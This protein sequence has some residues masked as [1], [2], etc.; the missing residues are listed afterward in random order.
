MNES[1]RG[2]AD[3]AGKPSDQFA[4]VYGELKR[5]ARRQL[6]NVP[7]QT[8]N[9]T[10]LVH[11][12]WLKLARADIGGVNDRQHFFA[13]AARAMR[14]IVVD[15]ARERLADK[16]GGVDRNVVELDEAADVP[17]AAMSPEELL[18]LDQVLSVLAA[19]EPRTVQLIELRFFAGLPVEEIARLLD[20]SE[21]TLNRDWRRARALLYANFYPES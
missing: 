21:R 5:I 6:A 8:L 7:A 9:T 10:G 15:Y 16:R 14:Q 12:A 4:R 13:I 19:D 11:E 17:S 1:E 20:V 3:G 2:D 18:H